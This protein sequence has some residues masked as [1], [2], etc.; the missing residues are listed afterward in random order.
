MLPGLAA[1][2]YLLVEKWPY[3][4]GR[5][6]AR[7]DIVVFRAPPSGRRTYVK[8]VIG[9]PGDSVALRAGA[10]LLDGKP[11]PRWRVAD[12]VAPVTA[13]DPCPD[14][15]WPTVR[16]ERQADGTI[17]CRSPRWREM[18]PG[19]RMIDTL[20]LG[21]GEGD[22]FGPVTVPAGRLFLLGDNRDR[23]ADSRW[24]AKE[25]GPV[26]LVPVGNLVGRA[27]AILFSVDGSARLARPRGWL[28]AVRWAR[29]GTGF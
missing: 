11:L 19:G 17:W 16:R 5:L 9:L 6:P 13:N 12:Y 23:S 10:I 21:A 22:D 27:R 14:E 4:G 29:I 24:P 3:R 26:G 8:R 7:G 2:D 18:L 1:G 28:S 25:G 20:D 15:A